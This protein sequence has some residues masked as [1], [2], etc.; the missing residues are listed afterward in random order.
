MKKSTLIQIAIMILLIII[1]FVIVKL[2]INEMS[3]D[4]DVKEKE[5]IGGFKESKVEANIEKET[6]AENVEVGVTI[7]EENIDLSNYST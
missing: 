6:T 4:I 7:T 5:R 1:L 2:T 3:Y